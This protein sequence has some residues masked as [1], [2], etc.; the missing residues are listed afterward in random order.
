MSTALH[1]APR[2]LAVVAVAATVVLAPAAHSAATST[3]GN[4]PIAFGRFDPGLGFWTL[5]TAQ[6]NGTHQRRLTTVPSFFSDWSPDGSTVAFDYSAGDDEHIATVRPDGSH[7]TRL[8][9]G[10]GIQEVPRYAPDGKHI[11]F[12]ASSQLPDDPAF[13]TDIW[14]MDADGSHPHQVTSDGFD[15]EP[16]Y[17]PDGR[18]IAFGRIVGPSSPTDSAQDEAVYVVRTD[19]TG[20]RRVVAPRSGLE[21]PRWSP[22]G[23]LITFNIAPE[24]T[25]APGAGTVYSVHPDGSGLTVVRAPTAD[26][27]FTKAVWSPDGHTMLVVCH[28]FAAG[29][30][31]I[32]RMDP[33]TGDI[34]VIVTTPPDR[35]V[36]FPS[37]GPRPRSRREAGG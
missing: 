36:N 13:H 35:P 1:R 21:H 23:R 6:A 20:L 4:G 19:G 34:H 33:R 37:W 7:E 22:D 30:D 2:L 25:S 5:W 24:A 16:V 32:C 14:E 3:V 12:D 11:V 10:P 27:A 15:V 31:F 28:S 26:W 18:S 9:S 8:T 29:V 17:S